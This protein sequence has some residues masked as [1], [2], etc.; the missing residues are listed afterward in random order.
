MVDYA[1]H[2]EQLLK[3]PCQAALA[4]VSVETEKRVAVESQER[5]MRCHQR[6]MALYYLCLS[7]A[8]KSHE[9]SP[10]RPC[11]TEAVRSFKERSKLISLRESVCERNNRKI[12]TCYLRGSLVC[13]GDLGC[14]RCCCSVCTCCGLCCGLTLRRRLRAAAQARVPVQRRREG[15]HAAPRRQGCA[16]V[17]DGQDETA[18]ASRC[19]GDMREV[20]T[21]RAAALSDDRFVR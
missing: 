6:C 15:G 1:V 10:A 16:A 13:S 14:V 20:K 2:A 5:C 11:R 9:T 19:C 12:T 4:I 3:E 17:R 18:R 7:L 21:L 8:S